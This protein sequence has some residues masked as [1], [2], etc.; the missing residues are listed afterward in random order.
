MKPIFAIAATTFL[1]AVIPTTFAQ[2]PDSSTAAQP[3]AQAPTP[4]EFDKNATKMQEQMAKMQEQMRKIQQTKDPQ[5]RQRLLQEHWTTMQSAMS[6]MNEGYGA[7]M[8]GCCGAQ[9]H[10]MSGHTP[11]PMMWGDYR[12]L[13]PEQLRGRQYMMDRWMPMQHMM[14]EQMMQHYHWMMPQQSPSTTAP[15]K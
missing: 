12:N 6:M 7:M 9:G 10:M 2:Q 5:E 15:K 3:T 8:T 14:M 1:A 4:A 11:G 13:T